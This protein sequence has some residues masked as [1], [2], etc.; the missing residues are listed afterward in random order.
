[1]LVTI[2][3][4][5]ALIGVF[6]TTTFGSHLYEIFEPTRKPLQCHE[7]KTYNVRS[8]CECALLC[9]TETKTCAGYSLTSGALCDVCFIHDVYYRQTALRTLNTTYNAFLPVISKT[10]GK[11]PTQNISIFFWLYISDC[12]AYW[13][14]IGRDELRLNL[15]YVFHIQ[16]AVTIL[17][18]FGLLKVK[19]YFQTWVIICD[20]TNVHQLYF[21]SHG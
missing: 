20:F 12:V 19:Q 15:F 11:L 18:L 17:S 13:D 3:K 9:R 5:F 21:L 4:Q 10:V 2:L 8:V 7:S 14:Q 1:M 6:A 16:I